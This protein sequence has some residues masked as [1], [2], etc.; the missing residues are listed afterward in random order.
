M[1]FGYCTGFAGGMTGPVDYALLHQIDEAGYDYAELPLMQVAALDAQAFSEL[2]RRAASMRIGFDACCNM[3]PA[4]VR[5]LGEEA[6][7]P[8]IRA[9]LD[10]AFERMHALHV[11]K[12]VLGSSGARALPAGMSA[13]EGSRRLSELVAETIVP[14][15]EREDIT[16]VIEPIGSY[17]ANFIHTLPEG[18]EIVRQVNHPRVRLLADS[19]HLLY[20]KET[21]AHIT[22]YAPYLRHIH[23]CET[24]RALPGQQPSAGLEAILTAIRQAGYEGTVSFE[25][26]P[27]SLEQMRTALAAVRASL[28]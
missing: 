15:L 8:V 18:M 28:V 21:P 27:H 3:F 4:Q 2:A 23:L 5:L 11:R 26:T 25:P 13:S 24:A 17:E 16:L 22:Q 6:S 10:T 12:I 14:Y 9:Y 20:E 7:L 19:V 1:R